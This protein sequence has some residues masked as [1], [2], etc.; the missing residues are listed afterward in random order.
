MTLTLP[1]G[2]ILYLDTSNTDTPTWV[3]LSEHNRS[4]VSLDTQRIERSQRM[5]NGSLR[6]IF[7]AD[8]KSISTTWSMLPSYSSMTV[9]AGYGAVDLKSFYHGK[10]TGSF[11]VKISYNGVSGRDEIITA[12]FTS[13]SF[14][15]VKRNVKS[16]MADVAQ[17]FW[18]VSIS[19]EEV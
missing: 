11:K 10:G 3:K 4:P 1:V 9:D 15:V 14:T 6:K 12:V 17:E 18:D 5:A 8:K 19:L 2:S 7:I 13:C 16:N